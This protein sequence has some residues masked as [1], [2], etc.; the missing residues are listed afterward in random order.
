MTKV[1]IKA[2][3]DYLQT[4]WSGGETNQLFLYPEDGDYKKREF[5]YRLSTATVALRQTTFT[6]LDGYHRILM[7]LDKPITLS[8]LSH[9]KEI[10]L[11]PFEP[12]AFEGDTR[13]VSRGTCQDINLMYDDHYQGQLLPVW[14]DTLF[15]A[16]KADCQLLYA[17]SKLTYSVTNQANQELEAN[18]LL[19]IE[20]EASLSDLKVCLNQTSP[21]Q[22]PVAVWAGLW[23]K[24]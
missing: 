3:S 11:A 13:I 7:S 22:T 9:A 15:E 2:P 4:D 8:D 24:T 21:A 6:R 16:P 12:Y 20:Q 19:V 14:S 10:S 23:Y 1:T 5:S 17:L 18:H